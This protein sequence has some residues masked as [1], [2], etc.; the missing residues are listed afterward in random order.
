MA[1]NKPSAVLERLIDDDYLHEQVATGASRL[2][3]A[4]VRSRRVTKRQAIQDER[5]YDHVRVAAGALTEA[6]RR[7]IGK[8]EPKP[9]PKRRGR[10]LLLLAAAGRRPGRGL[11]GPAG[12]DPAGG[13]SRR[14]RRLPPANPR[15]GRVRAGGT[16][17][18]EA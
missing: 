10:R 13:R 2:R 16:R 8:P 3:R 12:P 14:W 1:S 6:T 5:L 7:A 4:Y 15:A 18:R 9:E 11:R 17:A